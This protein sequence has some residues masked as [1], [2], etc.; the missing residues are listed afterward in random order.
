[1][2][3]VR[4]ERTGDIGA[5]RRVNELA[6]ERP[7]EADLVDSLRARGAVTF[8]LVA[9]EVRAGSPALLVRPFTTHL[10]P[11]RPPAPSRAVTTA[12][13]STTRAARTRT[14]RRSAPSARATCRVSCSTT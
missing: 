12:P 14:R 4:P 3:V 13:R 9:V 2:A 7:N 11:R 6:F 10:L 1:M 8:S 5:I